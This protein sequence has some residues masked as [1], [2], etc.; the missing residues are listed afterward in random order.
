M[1]TNPTLRQVGCVHEPADVTFLPTGTVKCT[2]GQVWVRGD[3]QY[4]VA[5]WGRKADV[6]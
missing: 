5:R 4:E 2:C 6:R 1:A 3:R